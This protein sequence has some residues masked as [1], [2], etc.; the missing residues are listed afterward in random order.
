MIKRI[1]ILF[2]TLL[3]ALSVCS[4]GKTE[5]ITP[6]TVTQEETVPVAEEGA[7]GIESQAALDLIN[8]LPE[9]EFDEVNS[10]LELIKEKKYGS[11]YVKIY[12]NNLKN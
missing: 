7:T 11:K 1:S 5:K 10:D 4:C 8:N 6:D 9:Y 2:L 3:L 12:K